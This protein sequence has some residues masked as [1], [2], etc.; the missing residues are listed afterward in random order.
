[1]TLAPLLRRLAAA[2]VLAGAAGMAPAADLTVSAAASLTNAFKEL[3]P[4]FEAAH[5]GDR[6][7]FN[8]GASD[9]LLAQIV[10]G[11]PADVFAAADQ[12][13][14]DRAAAQ[15]AIV[16]GTRRDFV[17]NTLVLI[18][19]AEG[20]LGL[21]SPADLTRTEVRRIALGN[22]A[23]VPAGRYARAALT[24]A[25]LWDAV[26]PKAVFAQSVRQA[27]DYVAR[28]EVEAG[29]VYATDAAIMKD[30]VRVV[31][32][33]P[34]ASPVTYPIAVVAG[35]AQPEA[36]RRFLDFLGTPGARA[37]LAR[38]GFGAP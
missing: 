15:Q 35:S 21:R 19:P 9:A 23:S 2:L 24:G 34:T 8:F 31:A 38:Y 37:V 30:K 28:G 33:V 10:R 11:A 3:G 6:A 36:A 12:E 27:L 32:G 25:G 29:F 13:S 22:P 14:M 7:V 17:A 26:A 5:P 20:G 16:A 4:L 1:M 18:E